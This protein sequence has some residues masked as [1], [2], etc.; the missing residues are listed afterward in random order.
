MTLQKWRCKKEQALAKLLADGITFT[1]NPL[2]PRINF[3]QSNV[4]SDV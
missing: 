2:I 4:Q 1:N 3:E